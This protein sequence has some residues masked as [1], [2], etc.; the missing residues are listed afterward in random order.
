MYWGIAQAVW[1]F[2]TVGWGGIYLLT[3]V[4]AAMYVMI[5]CGAMSLWC[6]WRNENED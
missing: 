1:A 4:P 6:H 2:C 3:S 5:G